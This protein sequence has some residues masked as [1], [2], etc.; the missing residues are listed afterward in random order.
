MS[1]PIYSTSPRKQPGWKAGRVIPAVVGLAA[2]V[3][4]V[5]VGYA[6]KDGHQSQL[7]SAVGQVET[8]QSE[9]QA[10]KTNLEL[11]NQR[12]DNAVQTAKDELRARSAALDTRARA[13]DVRERKVTGEERA[14][15]RDSI[16]GDGEFVVGKEI[17]P[18]IYHAAASGGCYWARLSS[19]D[20][21]AIIDN[22]NVDGPVTIEIFASDRAFEDTRCATFHKIG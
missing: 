7:R 19:L 5:V 6:V 22:N 16:P 12:A 20:T 14:W 15:A 4:G 3:A 10:A 11:A 8:L 2:L 1:G 17:K 18:G 13:L 9:L 21:S